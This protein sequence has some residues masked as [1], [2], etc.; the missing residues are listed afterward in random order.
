MKEVVLRGAD[1]LT[2]SQDYIRIGC[3]IRKI[4]KKELYEE[5]KVVHVLYLATFC[6]LA[7][8]SGTL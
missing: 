5:V 2:K 1:Y 4:K 3:G 6:G 7:W 8:Y